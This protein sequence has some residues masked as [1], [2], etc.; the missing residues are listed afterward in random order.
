MNTKYLRL[1]G[2]GVLAAVLASLCCITPL[3]ALAS[4]VFGIASIFSWMEPARP[5]LIGV[6]VLV[7]GFSWYQK[8]KPGTTEVAQCDCK[9]DEKPPFIQ[10]KMFLGIVTG[11]A[12]LMLAFPY[13]GQI[14]Y[15]ATHKE[16]VAVPD[17]NIQTVTFK[18]SG[19]TCEGCEE[20]IKHSVDNQAGIISVSASYR[21]G[22]A[23]VKFDNSKTDKASIVK[24]I[25]STGYKVIGEKTTENPRHGEGGHVCGPNG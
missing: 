3:L 4:G 16:I 2:V 18:V 19:M 15:P 1:S 5:Y 9:E 10:T 11:F 17:H 14:F 20:H 8:L 21:E 23:A 22:I 7:L 12:F 6:T 13:Y 24:M 25:S